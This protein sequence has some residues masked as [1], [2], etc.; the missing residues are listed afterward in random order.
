MSA[1]FNGHTLDSQSPGAEVDRFPAESD[2]LSPAKSGAASQRDQ[3]PV[4]RGNGGQEL[5]GEGPSTDG[6]P[7]AGDSNSLLWRTRLRSIDSTMHGGWPRG[8]VCDGL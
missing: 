3:R 8:G 1:D 4:T 6:L 7:V 2:A 5:R